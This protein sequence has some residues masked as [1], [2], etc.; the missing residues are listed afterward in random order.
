MTVHYLQRFAR[1]R[2]EFSENGVA[3]RLQPRCAFR[4]RDITIELKQR[5]GELARVASMLARHQVTLKAGSALAIGPRLIARFVPSDIEAARRALDAA[6]IRFDESEVVPVVLE[7]RAG[8]L[9]MLSTRLSEAGIAVR[10]LYI[11]A[12][13][14]NLVELA[15]VPDNAAQAKRVLQAALWVV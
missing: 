5:P 8:E 2:H 10:A 3:R 9:A 6:A 7:S 12:T 15:V 4:M 13:I 1:R 14:G 11:T